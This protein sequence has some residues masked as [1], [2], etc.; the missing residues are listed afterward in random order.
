M[1]QIAP[2]LELSPSEWRKSLDVDLA[3][4]FA[5]ARAAIPGMLQQGRGKIIN[6]AS[7]AGHL[8]FQNRAAYCATKAGLI[9]LTKTI[10]LEYGAPGIWCNAVAP[11]VVET[12]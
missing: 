8:A 3:A 9:T 2:L 7:M 6:I 12:R 11:G 4:P 10:T 5:L 1:R